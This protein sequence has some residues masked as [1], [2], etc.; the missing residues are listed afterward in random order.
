MNRLS[1]V[2]SSAANA[3]ANAATRTITTNPRRIAALVPKLCLG[4]HL[5]PKLCFADVATELPGQSHC[6]TEF[7][8]EEEKS[9]RRIRTFVYFLSAARASKS[10][11]VLSLSCAKSS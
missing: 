6:Q 9:R 2:A 11:T 4:T 1:C 5:S 8:N 7:G 3:R 10:H